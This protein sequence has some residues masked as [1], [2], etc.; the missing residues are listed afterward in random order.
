[1]NRYLPNIYAV[2]LNV[3]LAAIYGVSA[4]SNQEMPLVLR[5]SIWLALVGF[6]V[7]ELYRRRG[8]RA[9]K[10]PVL[11]ILVGT[12]MMW[13]SLYFA[14]P[15]LGDRENRLI[16]HA[17]T[18]GLFGGVALFVA[19]IFAAFLSQRRAMMDRFRQSDAS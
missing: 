5:V 18:I 14:Y 12:L 16:L 7:F 6:L 4:S 10:T 19:G 8:T 13:S 2:G 17:G 11:L 15:N 9:E 3:P 1:M